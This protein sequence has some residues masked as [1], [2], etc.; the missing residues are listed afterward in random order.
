MIMMNKNLELA[1]L[2]ENE[3][4]QIRRDLHRIPGEKFSVDQTYQYVF[5]KLVEYGYEPR[6]C[7][8]CG[9]VATIGVPGKTLLLR[10]DLDGLPMKEETGLPFTSETDCCHSCGHDLHMAMLLGAAKILKER[11]SELKGTV[12]II[13]QPGEEVMLGS[14][15]MIKDGLLENPKVDAALALHVWVGD[16]KVKTGELKVVIPTVCRSGDVVTVIVHG[17]AVHSSIPDKGIDANS[18][19]CRIFN[20]FEEIIANEIPRE[21][22]TV[23]TTGSLIGGTASNIVS[24][25][26]K[27]V[28]GIRCGDAQVRRFVLKRIEEISVYMAKAFRAEAE[29]ISGGGAPPLVN[30]EET[31]LEMLKY[32]AN[33]VGEERIHIDS[34]SVGIGEDF[35]NIMEIV[36]TMYAFIGAGAPSEGYS[37]A[38]HQPT[39]LF[40]EEALPYGAA[41]EA[42]VAINWLANHTE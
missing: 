37:G 40:N 9:I 28:I 27:L 41:V 5:N 10:A 12:K 30:D 38:L 36:P 20:G 7:G 13:F 22:P 39:V 16:E 26:C 3:L 8:Q 42:E 2:Y 19:G 17:K 1:K 21:C 11:E 4:V 34:E 33:V 25:T 32:A 29:V 6:R 31:C 18:I 15:D 23:I 14:A 24:D 35:G